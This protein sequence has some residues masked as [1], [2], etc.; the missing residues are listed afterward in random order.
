MKPLMACTFNLWHEYKLLDKNIRRDILSKLT[1]HKF[2]KNEI[3]LKEGEVCSGIYI[4]WRGCCRS[5]IKNRGEEV[6]TAFSINGN[7][8]FVATSFFQQI[9]SNEY[10]QTIEETSCYFLSHENL[11]ILLDKYTMFGNFIKRIYERMLMNEVDVG[12]LIRSQNALQ[13]Y[14]NF[15]KTTPEILQRVPLKYLASFL[16]MSQETLSRMRNRI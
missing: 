14:K 2:S 5:F 8:S 1:S 16:G 11:N 13:R 7:L 6:T 9:P 4:V 15:M 10:I 3:I 12:N